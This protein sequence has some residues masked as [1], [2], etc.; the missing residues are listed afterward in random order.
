MWTTIQIVLGLTAILLVLGSDKLSMPILGTMG[1]VCFGL[2]AMAIGWEAILTRQIVLGRRRHGNVQTYSGIPAIL[3]GV[4]FNLM[5]LF[6]IVIAIVVYFNA[7]GRAVFLQMVRR[8]GLPLIVFGM[9]LLMQAVITLTGSH[10][11][12]QGPRWI[13]I[14]NLLVSR[15]LPGVILVVL[16]LGATGLG[17]FEIVAPN[18]FDEMGG[19]FLEVLYGL[20]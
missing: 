4:Q 11:L 7:N 2:A 12:R 10:E 6:L 13:V 20:R 8:P 1:M 5:G 14:M 15:L 17:L 19:G 3:Q 9:L 18:V 16:G